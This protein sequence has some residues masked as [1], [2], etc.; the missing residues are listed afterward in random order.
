ME[1][2]LRGRR[3]WGDRSGFRFHEFERQSGDVAYIAGFR[4]LTFKRGG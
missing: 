2:E 3:C 4:N 1:R